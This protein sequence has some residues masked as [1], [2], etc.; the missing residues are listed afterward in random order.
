[1][2]A[3]VITTGSFFGINLAGIWWMK[4]EADLNIAD[5]FSLLSTSPD[6][7]IW[8][9]NAYKQYGFSVRCL[10]GDPPGRD[11]L[12]AVYTSGVMN[13]DLNSATCGGT[14]TNDGGHNV[15]AR[16]ICWSTSQN[17]TI[18]DNFTSDGS[19]TGSYSSNL[20]NLTANTTYYT[21][22]YATN[23]A[24]TGYGKQQSF[25]TPFTFNDID[26]NSYKA[27]H[28]GTQIWMNRNLNTSRYNDGTSIPNITVNEIWGKLTTDAFC[29]YENNPSY[30]DIYGKLYNWFA[31]NTGKLCP[32]GWHV[33]SDEEWTTLTNYL[34]GHDVAG[35][36]MKE[37]GT[38][39]WLSPNTGATN[40]SGFTA[41]PGGCRSSYNG[42]YEFLGSLGLWWT[43]TIS[44]YSADG[45]RN[46]LL[47]YNLNTA[48]RDHN[49]KTLG[50]SVRC[51]K[52]N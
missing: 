25:T 3:G 19:G 4:N 23:D 29:N 32:A 42:S 26:G 21:R 43:T 9:G 51:V 34:G 50:I 33:P 1:M 7:N 22:A 20:T 30:S 28:I 47:S 14:I 12:P 48:V 44:E 41:L 35:G 13:I 16:G 46:I 15:T 8:A 40:G 37:A 2:E 45:A 18:S 36:K 24:G 10:K 39:H 31:V 52:N 49:Y 11:T 38:T 17:P 6:V 5:A 27:L